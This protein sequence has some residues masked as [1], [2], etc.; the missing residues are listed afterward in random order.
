MAKI[1][2]TSIYPNIDPVLSDYF[3]VT[4]ANTDLATK[5]CTLESVQTL[6]GLADTTVTVT[7]SS[8][9][10]NALWTQPLT[11]L[12]APGD[13]YVLNV[14]NIIL[15][16]DAGSLVYGFDNTANATIGTFQAGDITTSTFNSATDIVENIFNGGQ[17]GIN[18]PSNTPLVLTGQGTTSGAGN[19]V[20]YI[21]ITYQ[22][23]KLDS[24]F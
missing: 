15:F 23:L 1:S 10:L 21:K 2:N 16:M 22:T 12:A 8:V 4:D 13:G 5:T 3:V 11:L 14:K 9:L 17:I 7:V 6:F 19:G 24:T 18:I 20:M